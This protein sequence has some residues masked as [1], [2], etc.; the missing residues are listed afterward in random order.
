MSIR[1]A[2]RPDAESHPVPALQILPRLDP[3]GDGDGATLRTPP[4]VGLRNGLI[5]LLVALAA[6][7]AVFLITHRTHHPSGRATSS[8]SARKWRRAPE[9]LAKV[10]TRAVSAALLGAAAEV[11]VA[12]ASSTAQPT[13]S[14]H[15]LSSS[16]LTSLADGSSIY[17]PADYLIKAYQSVGAR[18]HIPWRLLA[19]AEY[20]R[21]DYVD[22]IAGASAKA[23]GTVSKQVQASG[24][25]VVNENVLAQAT[26]AAAHP[27]AELVGDAK[28]LATDNS[29]QG[30]GQGLATFMQGTDSSEQAVLTLAQSIA[31]AA[32]S[33]SATPMAKVSAMLNEA[34]LLNGLPYVWGGG[35]T[36]PAWVVASG[37]DCSG[38]VSEVLHS[39]G[40]L[41]GPDTTQTLP[42]SPGIVNGPGKLVTIYDR[43][44]ATLKVWKLKKTT[45]KKIV[46]QASAGVHV[47]KGRKANSLNSVSI[48]LPKW[49]G[50][51]ELVKT[52]KLVQSLDNNNNDEHVIIDIDGQWWESGGS[53][54][55]GGAAMV[56]QIVDPNP[57][58][59]KTFNR[60]LHPQ[61]L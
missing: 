39:A 44:I 30:S 49:V 42:G 17:Q 43:T 3:A 61:G 45:V 40:Y 21:G 4:G 2:S 7:A 32:P 53:T 47:V 9:R 18:Y 34:Q 1:V 11:A 41:G 48:T 20:L 36:E 13:S 37:Y 8:A 60:I 33:A 54:G 5:A 56:H 6:A 46:N 51:W 38:F 28:R 19:S 59:L 24:S 58:Y 22:A 25:S 16:D 31:P 10:G 29:K 14:P 27:S 12:Q 26:A 55:D 52:K 23:V 15:S 50:E 57:A 35:H